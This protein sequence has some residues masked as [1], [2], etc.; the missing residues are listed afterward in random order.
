MV[1]ETGNEVIYPSGEMDIKRRVAGEILRFFE[2]LSELP[3][4]EDL[5]G[6]IEI[7]FVEIRNT[8]LERIQAGR[9]I[10][11]PREVKKYLVE[12]V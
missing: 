2:N 4:G 7:I 12:I 11:I 1:D 6:L 3:A 8:H 5:T 10:D 9:P